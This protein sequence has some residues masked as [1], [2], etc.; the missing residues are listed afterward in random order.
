MKEYIDTYTHEPHAVPEMVQVVTILHANLNM[1]L[2]EN[3]LI[4]MWIWIR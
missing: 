3:G 4:S 1:S 2:L